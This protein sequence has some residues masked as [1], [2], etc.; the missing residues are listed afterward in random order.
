MDHDSL[1][2]KALLVIE[3]MT[4]RG[5]IKAYAIGGAIAAT[6]YIEPVLTYDLDI[7]FIP[8]K[9]GLTFSRPSTIMPRSAASALRL[10]R[11]SLRISLSSSSR[12]AMNLFAKPWTNPRPS[13]TA[14]WKPGSSQRRLQGQRPHPV[15]DLADRGEIEPVGGDAPT[16]LTPA[17]DVPGLR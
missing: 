9:E 10:R 8:A 16:P 7:F 2:D 12:H 13:N 15:Q 1:K 17:D 14:M 5:I 4:R 6:Y 11:S 3:E